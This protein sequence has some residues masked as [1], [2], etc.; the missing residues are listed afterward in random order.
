[1]EA[2]VT[3]GRYD[4]NHSLWMVLSGIICQFPHLSRIQLFSICTLETKYSVPRPAI[5]LIVSLVRVSAMDGSMEGYSYKKSVI[6]ICGKYSK[7]LPWVS[8]DVAISGRSLLS[9][10]LLT[11]QM[12]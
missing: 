7:L 4:E 12:G 3:P 1:M 11:S 6:N 8:V 10:L 9:M 5:S 2:N